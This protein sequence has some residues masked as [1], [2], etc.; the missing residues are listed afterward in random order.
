MFF[1]GIYSYINMPIQIS[2]ITTGMTGL[3]QVRNGEGAAG[4][5]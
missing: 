2:A 5:K 1:F 4:I 3:N